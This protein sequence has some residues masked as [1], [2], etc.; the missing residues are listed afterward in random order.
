M[1][2]REERFYLDEILARLVALS[3]FPKI[4]QVEEHERPDFIL[5]EGERRIG[6]EI[7]LNVYEEYRK[8]RKL[9]GNSF[10]TTTNLV[11]T[12]RK[13]SKDELAADAFDFTGGWKDTGK[14]IEEWKLKVQD[15]LRKKRA[16]LIKP[17]YLQLP[18]NWLFVYDEPPLAN[19]VITVELATQAVN[20]IFAEPYNGKDFD[21]V[22]LLSHRYLYR[23][24]VDG[25]KLH[26]EFP[27]KS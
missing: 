13:R 26:Y 25:L 17:G 4:P 14:M 20:E 22:Y 3:D 19:D 11:D 8:A 5:T 9:F 6:A 21:R 24:G 7:T 16:K 12:G 1:N 27:K 10:I 23:F 2:K 15:T 18:E